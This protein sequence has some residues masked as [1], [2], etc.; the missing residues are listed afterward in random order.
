MLLFDAH[1]HLQDPRILDRTRELIHN[2]KKARGGFMVCCATREDDWN[3]VKELADC[4]QE[5]IP[6]LGIH[7]WYVQ[8][9]SKGWEADLEEALTSIPSGVGEIGLD[10]AVPS[11]DRKL[12]EKIFLRQ[13]EM[14]RE[15]GRPVS[16]H[17]RKAWDALIRIMKSLG[18]L[19]SG[20]L[21]HAYSG[22]SDL[23]PQLESFGFSIS[24]SGSLA[25]PGNK[26]SPKAVGAVSPDRL[27]LETDSP[28]IL[29]RLPET[30]GETINQPAF[31]RYYLERGAAILNIS[32]EKLADLTHENGC[33]LFGKKATSLP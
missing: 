12:Q 30:K 1:C 28:F 4:N 13:L 25:I 33:R 10:F 9:V 26:K 5:I 2:W 8:S 31:L 21:I 24:F 6:S 23:I 18:T 20:G 15:L 32:P 14:A 17:I 29:P 11:P 22:S 7:P 27:L 16:V 19:K 3:T